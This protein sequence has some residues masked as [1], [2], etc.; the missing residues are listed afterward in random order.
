[1]HKPRAGTNVVSDEQK[2]SLSMGTDVC[3][4]ILGIE[5]H[6]MLTKAGL[7]ELAQSH[8]HLRVTAKQ[9]FDAWNTMEALTDRPDYITYLGITIARGPV[10]PEFFALSCAPDL[11]TGLQR[12]SLYKTLLGPTQMRVFRENDLLRVE[13]HCVDATLEVPSSLGALHIVYF[14]EAARLATAHPISPVEAT[15]RAS[16]K[17]RHDIAGHLGVMPVKGEFSALAYSMTDAKR[18]FISE[19]A[20]LWADFEQDLKRQLA[21]QRTST[22]IAFQVRTTLIELFPMGRFSAEDV[23][24]SLAMSRSTLQR[25]LRREGSSFQIVLD[26]TRKELAIRYLTKSSLHINEIA[27]LLAYRDPN[28]FSRAF[29][30]WTGQAPFYFRNKV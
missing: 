25:G 4:R 6:D 29:R 23:C 11:E 17:E 21:Q 16:K 1:M 18:P 26:E 3:C 12:L 28:S 30:R 22:S 24:S 13:Y 10:I 20:R 27:S 7:A 14:V 2:Y 15:L 8:G 5:P 19:N 9:Y